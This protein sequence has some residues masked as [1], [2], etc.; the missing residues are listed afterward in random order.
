MIGRRALLA[1]VL[2]AGP[3]GALGRT[4]VGGALRVALP[5]DV[6]EL[7][8]HSLDDPLAALFAPAVADPLFALDSSGAPY[9]ALAAAL[10]ERAPAGVRVTLR[11][12]LSS[13]R[14]RSLTA[15]DAVLSLERARKRGA[16]AVLAAFGSPAVDRKDPLA[17]VVPS[18]DPMALARALSSPVTALVPRGFSPLAPDGTGAF[19]AELSRGALA[20]ERNPRAARG[21]AFLDR[22]EVREAA[23][24]A[25]ALRAFESERTDLGWLGSGLHRPRP[26][27]V[28]FEGPE[29]GWV[30][31]RTGRDAASWGA[32]G[33]AQNVL[34]A[35][36]LDRLRHLGV[37]ADAPTRRGASWGGGAADLVVA[38][39]PQLAEIATSLASLLSRPGHAVRAAP[40]A[41]AELAE[42]RASGRFALM[43]DFVRRIGPP[44][45][46][47]LHALLA[48]A[49]PGLAA[50]PPEAASYEPREIARRLPLGVVGSLVV[51]GARLPAYRS[52]E[53]WELGAVFRTS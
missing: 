46:A 3:A 53:A 18:S 21:G 1:A 16:G 25:T 48:A 39:A 14:G 29:Y 31:L 38:D 28:A 36:P 40:V 6:G 41:R 37:S 45:P 47:T 2:A 12:G 49:S 50:R 52:L 30:V 32:P 34:D 13:A 7:D 5:L 44:G 27:A 51:S 22:I 17:F 8:P 19:R 42:R 10:P 23:D 35:L 20:L 4:P 33:V 11:P 26:G 24:L 9:P 43:L 15:R